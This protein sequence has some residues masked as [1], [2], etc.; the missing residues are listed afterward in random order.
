M[1]PGLT[2]S[3]AI[4]FAGGK[5]AFGKLSKVK[6]VRGGRPV[7]TLNLERAGSP[8][9]PTLCWT[10]KTKSSC[11]IDKRRA[12]MPTFSLASP[13]M[14]GLGWRRAARRQRIG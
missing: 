4:A 1:R 12:A 10:L 8:D 6:L 9:P 2:V 11:Q 3:K 13:P 7:G 5:T 14:A